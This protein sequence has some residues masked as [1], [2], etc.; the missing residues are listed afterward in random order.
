MAALWKP[1]LADMVR[2]LIGHQV[3]AK[4]ANNEAVGQHSSSFSELW[5]R[6]LRSTFAG[7]RF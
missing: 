1:D 6:T 7:K 2:L 5:S 4:E 3:K